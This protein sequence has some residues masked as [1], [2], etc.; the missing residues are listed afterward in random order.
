MFDLF[1]LLDNSHCFKE[2]I[3]KEVNFLRKAIKLNEHHEL[4][5]DT[6][7]EVQ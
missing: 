4:S 2:S 5:G 3:D 1:D 7:R 6:R